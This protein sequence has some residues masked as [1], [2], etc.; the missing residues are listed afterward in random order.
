[1][2]VPGGPGG[3]GSGYADSAWCSDVHSEAGA[4]HGDGLVVL[5]PL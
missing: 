5:T 4:R 1:M 3:G 2:G